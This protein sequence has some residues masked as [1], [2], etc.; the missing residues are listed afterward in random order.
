MDRGTRRR[1]GSLAEYFRHHLGENGSNVRITWFTNLPKMT[2]EE[3]KTLRKSQKLS[4]AE[5][6]KRSN[7]T[8]AEISR[9]ECGY[10][11]ITD[12]ESASI[13]AAL[14][15]VL[16][17]GGGLA[18]S[19]SLEAPP[20]VVAGAAPVSAPQTIATTSKPVLN[21]TDLSDPVNFGVLPNLELLQQ[22]ALD[23]TAFRARLSSEITRA[24]TILHTPR[25]PA[26]V[27]RAW[28]QFEQQG[29]ALLRGDLPPVQPAPAAVP[30][31]H[32]EVP[33]VL[34]GKP[35]SKSFNSLF[36][37]AARATLAPELAARINRAAETARQADPSIGFM[38]HFR[39][40]AENEL[41]AAALKKVSD[42]A[43]E[44]L[45]SPERSR[46]RRGRG[47]FSAAK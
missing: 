32:V 46:S 3:I 5:L 37:E 13:A 35:E 18:K 19:G 17:L 25:V 31:A 16:K 36:V 42:A 41:D 15:V 11:D 1:G 39:R 44:R 40:I 10:K 38:K 47:Q 28:R 23:A 2:R 7:L 14:G 29:A 33:P 27:W 21:G 20:V 43:N 8:A 12:A 30:V 4:Q 22:G 26:S 34:P 24:N 45:G 6:G 9:I